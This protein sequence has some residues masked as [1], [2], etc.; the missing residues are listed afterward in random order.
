[1]SDLFGELG[2]DWQGVLNP[3]SDADLEDTEYNVTHSQQEGAL[4]N[5]RK[6][7][8]GGTPTTNLTFS[9]YQADNAEVF[10]KVLH[11]HVPK[12]ALIADVTYGKGV[13]WRNVPTTEYTV[14]ASDVHTEAACHADWRFWPFNC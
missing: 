10:P 14:L 6:R 3:P 11:L 13:F 1:M 9:A 7:I 2:N 8:Q 5:T 12:G 4:D